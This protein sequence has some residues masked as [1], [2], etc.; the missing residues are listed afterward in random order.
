M[1][2]NVTHFSSQVTIRL[3]NASNSFRLAKA[4]QMEIRSIIFLVLI[5]AAPKH[6]ASFGIQL[7]SNGLIVL[8]GRSLAPGRY[9]D[10]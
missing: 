7:C 6:R 10:Y 5:C 2:S 9:Y 8:Y 1:L 4:S 3:R